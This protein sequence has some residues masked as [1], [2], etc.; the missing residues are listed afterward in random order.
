MKLHLLVRSSYPLQII[1]IFPLSRNVRHTSLILTT[2]NS[3]NYARMVRRPG[4]HGMLVVDLGQA[5][6]TKQKRI[7]R[8]KS[9]VV[10]TVSVPLLFN[11]IFNIGIV[12]LK[13]T[14]S[15]ASS[16][17]IVHSRLV[18][19]FVL[20]M[21]LFQIPQRL[22]PNSLNISQKFHPPV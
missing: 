17:L 19:R 2:Q 13:L 20:L 14:M 16:C 4:R 1:V 12:C 5:H 6:Y 15:D 18:V 21:V 8:N 11:A 7:Q 10:L 3:K 9:V 22:P